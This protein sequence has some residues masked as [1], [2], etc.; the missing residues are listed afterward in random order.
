VLEGLRAQLALPGAGRIA[1]DNLV[2]AGMPLVAAIVT[3]LGPMAGRRA[4]RIAP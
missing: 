4:G 2:R 3:A 1:T